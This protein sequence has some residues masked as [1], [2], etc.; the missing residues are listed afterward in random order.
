[1][2]EMCV[3][4]TSQQWNSDN[5]SAIVGCGF[6]AVC[7]TKFVFPLS[8]PL[9]GGHESMRPPP[10]KHT[11]GEAVV[12]ITADKVNR[13]IVFSISNY[14]YVLAFYWKRLALLDHFVTQVPG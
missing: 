5:S 2:F 14:K 1:M 11:S 7:E 9:R 8:P 3:P 10:Q 6:I 13:L 4:E 12:Y